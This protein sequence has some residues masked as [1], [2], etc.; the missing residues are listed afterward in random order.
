[1]SIPKVIFY[2]WFGGNELPDYAMKCIESWK[3]YCPDYKIEQVDES[4]FD[5]SDCPYAVEAYKAKKYAF[6]TDYVRLK[7][8]YDEGGI[9]FDTDVE[10]VRPID[11][12]MYYEGFAGFEKSYFESGNKYYVSTGL[13]LAS[14]PHNPFIGA[15]L[16]DYKGIHFNDRGVLDMT[17]CPERNTKA[18]VKMGVIPNNKLQIVD[19]FLFAPSDWFC[20]KNFVTGKTK[21]TE[22]SRAVH[23]YAGSWKEN[24]A[25]TR[26][27]RKVRTSRV[28]RLLL[29]IKYKLIG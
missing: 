5:I 13:G 9:Y 14:A 2:C 19:N 25:R 16:E 29:R 24:S 26:L 28:G 1:M 22:N 15:M 10:L 23:L 20:P 8:L 12:L 21:L 27:K 18:L 11:D 6:V 4:N 7:K 17:P 3:K